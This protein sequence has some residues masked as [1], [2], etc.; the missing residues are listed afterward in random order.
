MYCDDDR[1]SIPVVVWSEDGEEIMGRLDQSG[2]AFVLDSDETCARS[3][4]VRVLTLDGVVG[5]VLK[6]AVRVVDPE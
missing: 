1:S 2:A 6:V 3:S 5:W 4:Y